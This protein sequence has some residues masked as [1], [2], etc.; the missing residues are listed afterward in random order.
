ML[1]SY[2][3][4]MA[5]GA[6]Y[7]Q[8]KKLNAD[9]VQE[10][11]NLKLAHPHLAD[12]IRDQ[13][14]C[15]EDAHVSSLEPKKSKQITLLSWNMEQWLWH[16]RH[17]EYYTDVYMPSICRAVREVPAIT[18]LGMCNENALSCT[19]FKMFVTCF[20]FRHQFAKS[21]SLIYSFR[22]VEDK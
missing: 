6:P 20:K 21:V 2:A 11:E 7:V 17:R 15:I 19:Y 18:Q 10:T 22:Y 12:D 8:A 13:T 9:V 16:I 3:D 14:L 5:A 4:F 1:R